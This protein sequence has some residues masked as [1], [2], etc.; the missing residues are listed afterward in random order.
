MGV[1]DG[2]PVARQ[3]FPDFTHRVLKAH[4]Y[5]TRVFDHAQHDG[6]QRSKLKCVAGTQERRVRTVFG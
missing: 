1:L 2:P 4:F 3:S 6:T 5:Q